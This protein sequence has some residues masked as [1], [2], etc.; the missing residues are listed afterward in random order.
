MAKLNHPNLI[1]VFDSGCV[2]QMLYFVMEFVPG[3]SLA[4]STEGKRSISA[5]PCAR[6][7][8]LRRPRPRPQHEIVHGD[9]NPSN[10]LL[11]QKAEPKIGNFGL[12]H[13]IH[14]DSTVNAPTHFTAPEVLA[15]PAPRDSAD[16]HL[17]RRRHSL[18]TDHRLAPCPG[19][20][21]ALEPLALRPENRRALAPGHRS[22]IRSQR[23]GRRADISGGSQEG[24][25][26]GVRLRLAVQA[27]ISPTSRGRNRGPRPQPIAPAAATT[28]PAAHGK[29]R[30]QL[31]AGAKPHHHRRPA[32]RDQVRLEKPRETRNAAGTGTP[33][34]SPTK[35]P[36]RSRPMAE[37]EK[38]AARTRPRKTTAAPRLVTPEQPSR[39]PSNPRGIPRPPAR[40]PGRR[41]ARRKCPSAPCNKGD[42]DYFLVT[43]PMSWPRGRVVRGAPRRPPGDPQCQG[44]S[45]LAGREVAEG[46]AVWIGAARS[47]AIH[48]R[49][50]MA[51]HGNPTRNPT[52]IGQ[53]LATDKHGFLHAEKPRIPAIRSSSSG[54]ATAPIPAALAP[55]LAATRASLG[56]PNPVF[57]PGRAPSASATISTSPAPSRGVRPSIWRKAPAATSSSF[58]ASRNPSTSRK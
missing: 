44:R 50:P 20:P 5:R 33:G 38:R 2:E 22:R 3:K 19:R 25:A 48:G 45:H 21:A 28:A 29:R 51:P 58:P 53:Y 16:G 31:E 10:I 42:N 4:R 1:S 55:L 46:K 13:P 34:T 39:E 57:P 27:P 37:A 54:I 41:H 43:E 36:P 15:H 7:W 24:R 18:R 23:H 9:L 12:S 47:G 52:G 17:R 56:Q 40:R 35:Q 49:L 6:R 32:L 30:L 26:A 8:H 14:A 11:N